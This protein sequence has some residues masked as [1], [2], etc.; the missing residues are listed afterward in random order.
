MT[1]R[2]ARKSLPLLAGGD[3]SAWKERKLRAHID[4]CRD[5]RR[6]LEELRSAIARVKVAAREE[7]AGEWKD[8]EWKALMVRATG[9]KAERKRPTPFEPRPR[10]ALA[11][12][13]A[14]LVLLAVIAFLFR[15]SIFKFRAA[16][17]GQGTVVVKKE[18]PK[19]RPEQPPASKPADKEGKG[20]PVIQPEYLA[21][22]AGKGA[23][24]QKTSAK[25]T[26]RQDILSVTM[27][28]RETGLQVVWFFNKNFEWKGDQK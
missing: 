2:K 25:G 1:C 15:D 14:A 18:E 16:G 5:C 22:N 27:V 19:G 24:P 8:A 26:A 17:P 9:Q 10:W 28:S 6:E 4:L 3:L 23:P 12:G 20:V 21:K 11:S 7:G 13:L